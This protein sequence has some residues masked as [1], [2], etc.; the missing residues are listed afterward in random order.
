MQ[1]EKTRH[2]RKQ[3]PYRGRSMRSMTAGL[4]EEKNN[5]NENTVKHLLHA[6]KQER[7]G[8]EDVLDYKKKKKWII[9][10]S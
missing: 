10:I 9:M 4:Q 7:C 2:E 3:L 6:E 8:R 1:E 5:T